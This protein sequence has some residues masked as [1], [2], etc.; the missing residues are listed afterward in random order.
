MI[1][2]VSVEVDSISLV[3]SFV[4]ESTRL[5]G[6]VF[7]GGKQIKRSSNGNWQAE[8]VFPAFW[9]VSSA[10]MLGYIPNLQCMQVSFGQFRA[11]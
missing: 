10:Q 4:F 6:A 9:C 2:S 8:S 7:I 5:V 3:R 11:S 1:R